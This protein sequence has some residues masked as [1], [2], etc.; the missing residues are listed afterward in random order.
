MTDDE[1]DTL[2]LGVTG[3]WPNWQANKATYAVAERLLAGLPY[4]DVEAALDALA[5]ESPRWFPGPGELRVRAIEIGAPEGGAPEA[6][7]A[8]GEVVRERHR[9]GQYA[10]TALSDRAVSFSHPAI[11]AV[12]EALGWAELCTSTNEVA[13]RAHFLRLYAERVTRLRVDRATPP[14][15]AAAI[16]R[17]A[18]ATALPSGVR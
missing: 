10:G 7:E 6:D 14:S 17:A 13:D 1:F 11:A 4:T 18:E 3:L 16:S 15:V 2:M 8:W 9:A 5:I 12:V